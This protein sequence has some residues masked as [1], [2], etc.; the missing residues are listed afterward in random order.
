MT[1]LVYW[2]SD[3]KQAREKVFYK[4]LYSVLSNAYVNVVMH[5]YHEL[6]HESGCDRTPGTEF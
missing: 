1:K 3:T 2:V 6:C 5:L 4:M